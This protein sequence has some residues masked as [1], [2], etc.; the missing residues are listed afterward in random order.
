M[1]YYRMIPL[2]IQ[3]YIL[4]FIQPYVT[5]EDWRTCR[6][7]E[8]DAIG[9]LVRLLQYGKPRNQ[10]WSVRYKDWSFYEKMRF[11]KMEMVEWVQVFPCKSLTFRL[12]Y[13]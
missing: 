4:D 9:Q 8:S 12:R 2:E 6:N 1:K 10:F 13:G 7:E 3:Q 5:R 11:S